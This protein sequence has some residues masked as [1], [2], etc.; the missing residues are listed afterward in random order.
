[1]CASLLPQ[2]QVYKGV[3]PL[4]EFNAMVD[5]LTSAPCIA[6]EVA[7]RSGADAV[8]PFRELCGPMDPEMA[9]VLRP[10]SIRAQFG[11]SKTKNAIH[12][13]DLGEDGQLEVRSG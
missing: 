9:R 4:G 13:T 12:C 8:E 6:F 3:L 11:L 10:G 2:L 5:E 1:M 7:D